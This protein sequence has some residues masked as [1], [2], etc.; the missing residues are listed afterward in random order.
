[1]IV[2]RWRWQGWQRALAV[3]LVVAIGWLLLLTL[4]PQVGGQAPER[5]K[6]FV[7]GFYTFAGNEYVTGFVPP[8]IDT[9]YVMADQVGMLDPKLTEIY[10]WPITNEY[11]ADFAALNQRVPGRLEVSQA[12][13]VVATVDLSDYVVQVD[14]AKTF[15]GQQLAVGQAALELRAAFERQRTAYVEQVNLFARANEE[16]AR[17]RQNGENVTAP[18]PPAEF[19]LYST[20]LGRGFALTLAA[21]DYQ[22]RVLDDQGATVADSVRRLVAITPRRQGVGYEVVPQ[23]K[24]TFPEQLD[25]PANAIFALPA[26]VAYLRPFTTLEFNAL[27]YARLQRPQ[28]RQ[29]TA[30]RWTWV[31]TAALSGATLVT[32]TGA[33]RE[34]RQLASYVVEQVP[35]PARGYI[36]RAQAE[37]ST[38]P[39]G[40]DLVDYYQLSVPAD[41]TIVRFHLI[42]DAGHQFAGSE[43]DLI[44]STPVSTELLA[45]PIA[46]PLLAGA[47]VIGWRR[48]QVVTARSLRP[49]QRQRMA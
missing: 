27:E 17:R 4:T 43:R 23:E 7:Y 34:R 1:M 16:Y 47:A 6:R 33:A 26:G 14:Q 44:V 25:E 28:D 24:W 20:D 22:I 3:A 31:R 13:R 30:N 5:Q 46:L 38:Q 37:A 35:G 2:K 10:F 29:A 32:E 21:G 36:I 48:R 49:E 41:R 18:T 8:A 12:G 39:S 42:D 19:T 15:G 9:I 40:P 11:Q 45:V